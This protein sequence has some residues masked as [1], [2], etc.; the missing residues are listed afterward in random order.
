VLKEGGYPAELGREDM[1][2]ELMKLY[3]KERLGMR[4]SASRS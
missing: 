2:S 4:A 1:I 3:M